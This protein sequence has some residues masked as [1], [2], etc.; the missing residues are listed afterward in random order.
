L[1][2]E[3]GVLTCRFSNKKK[4]MCRERYSLRVKTAK[5]NRTI[6]CIAFPP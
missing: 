2:L 1:H 6:V 4:G 3:D 5:L